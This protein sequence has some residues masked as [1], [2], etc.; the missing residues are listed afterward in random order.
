MSYHETLWLAISASAPVIALASIVSVGD[1]YKLDEISE[2]SQAGGRE[3]GRLPVAINAGN[4]TLQVATLLDALLSIYNG[5]DS[6]HSF[7]FAV[8]S[9]PFGITLLLIS[10]LVNGSARSKA[11]KLRSDAKISEN[12]DGDA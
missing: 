2:Q 3:T 1:S 9:Q 4:M 8:L 5:R 7:V 6:T 11:K 12:G 10:T